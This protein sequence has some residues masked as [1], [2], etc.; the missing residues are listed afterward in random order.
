M[1][2]TL[3]V[4]ARPNFM[5]IAPIIRALEKKKNELFSISYRL[6]HT[7][8]HYDLVMNDRFFEQLQIPKP[9]ISFGCGGG[10]DAE[11]TACIMS[12]FEK[13]LISYRPDMVIV[14][15][16]VNSTMA[17]SI[18]TKKQQITLAHV[19]AGIRSFDRSMP[20]EINR[21]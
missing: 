4:G 8:Q 2:I 5:K 6:I 13:E 16:D 19:E 14:V 9:D 18:I 3:V 7:G 21:L 1:K 12:A 17:C 20:E 10:S 11:Q 15:G